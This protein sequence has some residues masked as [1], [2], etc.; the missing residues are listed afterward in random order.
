M[1]LAYWKFIVYVRLI[2]IW[3]VWNFIIESDYT[4]ALDPTTNKTIDF[5]ICDFAK[6]K[7]NNINAYANLFQSVNG[8]ETC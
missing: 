3:H 5:N 6:K 1:H 4:Y 7:C 8:T 2:E